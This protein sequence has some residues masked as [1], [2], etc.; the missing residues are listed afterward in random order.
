MQNK[1]EFKK[2]TQLESGKIVD[3]IDKIAQ[4]HLAKQTSDRKKKELIQNQ[5][6]K[7]IDNFINLPIPTKAEIKSGFNAETDLVKAIISHESEPGKQF[8]SSTMTG[9]IA[10][11]DVY[12]WASVLTLTT[13]QLRSHQPGNYKLCLSMYKDNAPDT[14]TCLFSTEFFF[15]LREG[16]PAKH[17]NQVKNDPIIRQSEFLQTMAQ[18]QKIVN[19]LQFQI[20]D[21][22]AMIMNLCGHLGEEKVVDLN[23]FD[24]FCI[25]KAEKVKLA[26]EI[27]SNDA[28]SDEEKLAKAK[29]NDIPDEWVVNADKKPTEA[30]KKPE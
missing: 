10:V 27:A 23:S 21:V 12:T 16:K 11:K 24:A 25:E 1:D 8:V 19:G 20:N 7:G 18:V 9:G 6:F 17:K 29:E 14:G 13:E 26:T 3:K 22:K 4:K 5:V 28:L 30:P 2:S 15:K